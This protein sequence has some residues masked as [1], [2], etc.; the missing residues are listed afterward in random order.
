[1]INIRFIN[2]AAKT[3]RA[4][5]VDSSSS[6]KHKFNGVDSLK[7]LFGYDRQILNATFAIY[8]MSIKSMGLEA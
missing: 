7:R 3:L 8:Q 1:M 5:E 4:V 6:N 2:A